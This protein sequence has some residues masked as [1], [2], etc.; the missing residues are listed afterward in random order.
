MTGHCGHEDLW[1]EFKRSVIKYS[2]IIGTAA[3]ALT[4]HFVKSYMDTRNLAK[5]AEI[6]RLG[7]QIECFFGPLDGCFRRAGSGFTA[8]INRYRRNWVKNNGGIDTQDD[9][10]YVVSFFDE[11]E[12]IEKSKGKI[13]DT[14]EVLEMWMA[15]VKDVAQPVNIEIRDIIAKETHLY[16][17]SYPE[18]FEQIFDL[19]AERQ[20]MLQ[21]WEK[22]DYANLRGQIKFPKQVDSLVR[23]QLHAKQARKAALLGLT[24]AAE[25]G[26]AGEGGADGSDGT[27][28]T[29]KHPV[30]RKYTADD[31]RSYVPLPAGAE[32][33]Q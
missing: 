21:Q 9:K 1:S 22:K 8:L 27:S 3:L 11:L 28:G 23:D 20:M 18:C 29:G 10:F 13:N 33:S 19:V 30:H 17:G 5:V 12:R 2:G 15:F 25:G 26:K 14:Q 4:G 32:A 24:I 31:R 6:E 16:D 7:K